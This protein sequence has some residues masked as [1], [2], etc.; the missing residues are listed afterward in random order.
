MD[1]DSPRK[2][3]KQHGDKP[4]KPKEGGSSIGDI[5]DDLTEQ[6]DDIKTC[7]PAEVP[8]RVVVSVLETFDLR[9]HEDGARDRRTMYWVIFRSETSSHWEGKSRTIT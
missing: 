1:Y 7:F 8:S 4:G 3:I 2:N 5:A 6:N 9:T